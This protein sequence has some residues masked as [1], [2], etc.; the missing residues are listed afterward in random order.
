M[1]NHNTSD[2]DGVEEPKDQGNDN[3]I[4]PIAI[5]GMGTNFMVF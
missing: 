4:E 1:V 3:G 5:V 2:V